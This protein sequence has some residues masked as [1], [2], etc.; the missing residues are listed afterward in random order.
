MSIQ[1]DQQALDKGGATYCGAGTRTSYLNN[2]TIS[3][4]RE[5]TVSWAVSLIGVL[6]GHEGGLLDWSNTLL[7]NTSPIN[8]TLS[9]SCNSQVWV[10][11]SGLK[12]ARVR[13]TG[14]YLH[15]IIAI[16]MGN[17]HHQ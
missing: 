2:S 6:Q 15:P 1:L 14:N 5:I 11:F 9:R 10:L 7:N 13:T 17:N 8:P 4:Q 3:T 12:N 16:K